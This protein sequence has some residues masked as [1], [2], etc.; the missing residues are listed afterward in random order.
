MMKDSKMPAV[1]IERAWTL[2]PMT[3]VDGGAV[4]TG[5][6]RLA[7]ANLA[8]PAKRGQN[9]PPD[10]K[11]KFGA[12]LLFPPY[13][14]VQQQIQQVLV[15]AYLDTVRREFPQSIGADGQPFGL[16]SPFHDQAEKQNFTGFT[17]GGIC[18]ACTTDF[19]PQCVDMNMNPIVDEK[20]LYSGVWALVAMRLY[21]YRD[22]KRGVS[23]GMNSVM[24]LQADTPLGGAGG[25]PKKDFAGV[26][27]DAQYNPHAGFGAS[28]PT[29]PPSSVLPP[30]APVYA[31]LPP[32]VWAPPPAPR[33]AVSL[34]D[35]I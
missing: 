8:H 23:F 24:I 14:I 18:F 28:A 21:A 3:L 2:N 16:H 10:K 4:R 25:D 6:V 13:P 27:I 33:P 15:P 19:K 22:K 9:D 12:T 30:A 31:S 11:M 1:W 32:P 7:F 5:P 17:P 26:K 29:L 34:D 20:A 35:L